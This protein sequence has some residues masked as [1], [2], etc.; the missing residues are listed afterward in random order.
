MHRHDPGWPRRLGPPTALL[1]LAACPVASLA[2]SATRP[3]G[4]ATVSIDALDAYLPERNAAYWIV[5]D[6]HVDV[7]VVLSEP[8]AGGVAI[9]FVSNAVSSTLPF[10]PEQTRRTHT[11]TY[12]SGGGKPFFPGWFLDFAYFSLLT[13]QPPGVT[14][15]VPHTLYPIRIR[16]APTATA[17]GVP[18]AVD[19]I[20]ALGLFLGWE[21]SI[22]CAVGAGVATTTAGTP[23]FV[24]TLRRYR[25]E[26]LDTTTSGQY[27]VDLY[28]NHSQDI[29]HAIAAVPNLA[30]RLFL[31]RSEWLAGLDALV[32]GQ[33]D[34]FSVT[35]QMQATLLGLL[36]S[37][38]TGGTP[39]LSAMIAFERERL[40]L[41]SIAGLSMSAFQ[42]QV[43]TLGGPTSI[44][45]RS[46]GEVKRLYRDD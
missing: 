10:G 41:D 26:V 6:D 9:P 43:E 22:A 42:N 31:Q 36:Q 5:E 34:G 14:R 8:L 12:S 33:G 23:L 38:E 20:C 27:Y 18:C 11:I 2:A 30:A 1:L 46:W 35:P 15:G 40:H 3:H 16:E 17:A 39:A 24:P 7:P 29:I 21:T 19:W 44:E 25:D 32:N 37:F 13:E 4:T 45:G 28:A